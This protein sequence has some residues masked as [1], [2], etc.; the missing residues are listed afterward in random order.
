MD[1][2]ASLDLIYPEAGA[3]RIQCTQ[4]RAPR[5]YAAPESGEV[6]VGMLRVKALAGEGA[7]TGTAPEPMLFNPGGPGG[8]GY[9]L[10]VIRASQLDE[11]V[12]GAGSGTAARGASSAAS[13]PTAWAMRCSKGSWQR[14]RASA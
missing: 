9:L 4:M 2:K 11:V 13:P 1:T 7:G 12:Q 5:D 14:W 10:S 6:T 8:D 3:L